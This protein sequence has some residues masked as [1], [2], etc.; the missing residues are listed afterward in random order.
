MKLL[1]S[2]L[3]CLILTFS[4]NGFE[5]PNFVIMF[6]DDLGYADIGPFGAKD[7]PTPDLDRMAKEG[8]NLSAF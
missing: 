1:F 6:M 3:V 8:R 7:F 2:K 5:R 4:S